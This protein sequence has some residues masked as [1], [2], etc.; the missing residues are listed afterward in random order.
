MKGIIGAISGDIIGS[1]RE[2]CPIKTKQFD[3]FE[4]GSCFTDDTVMTLAVAN[5][6]LEDKSSKDVLIDN[7]KYFGNEYINAGYGA[8]FLDWLLQESPKP[9]GSWANGSAMRVSPCAW[10]ADSLSEAQKLAETS[11]IVTHNHPEAVKGAL[12]TCDAIY[13]ARI[14]AEK[15]EI[16]DHVEV[17]YGYDLSVSLDDIRPFYK[18]DVS[19]KGSV[20]ESIICFLEAR[21]FEDTIRNAVSLGGDADTQAAIAG[22]IASAYWEIPKNISYRT[23]HH[24]DDFLLNVL[25]DFDEKFM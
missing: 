15:D 6:L 3:F 2:F 9:Y 11:A 17:R 18:F 13:L 25:I 20:P 8:R 21:D 7:L 24:L 22:S 16:R 12:A 19:C 23:I 5:W 4:K 1:T 14:G 10:A